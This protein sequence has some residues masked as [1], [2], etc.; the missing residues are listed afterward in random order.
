ML[1][2]R[3]NFFT[4]KEVFFSKFFF[5]EIFCL[6][7]VVNWLNLKQVNLK[8]RKKNSNNSKPTS[9]FTDFFV[10]KGWILNVVLLNIS[11]LRTKKTEL[12]CVRIVPKVELKFV[13]WKSLTLEYDHLSC[14]LLTLPK[15]APNILKISR[16]KI[17]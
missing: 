14:Y 6:F 12:L 3:P 7:L 11:I 5:V 9:C 16:S 4:S 13:Q 17:S 2:P 1:R 15:S 10:E 8:L